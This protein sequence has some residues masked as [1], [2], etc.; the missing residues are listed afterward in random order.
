MSRTQLTAIAGIALIVI[1]SI[2][3]IATSGD[4]TYAWLILVAGIALL[5]TA[6]RRIA[7]DR[8]GRRDK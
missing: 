8:E 5:A 1:Y 7:A 4:A 6:G 3:M 2:T